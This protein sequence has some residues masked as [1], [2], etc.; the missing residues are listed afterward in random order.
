MEWADASN[1]QL[2]IDKVDTFVATASARAKQLGS[3]LP[4]IY[5]NDASS[6]QNPL[7]SYGEASFQ[8]IKTIAG[9]YDP[10]GIMQKVQNNGFLVSRS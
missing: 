9:K 10:S 2:A 5:V 7:R 6:K 8:Y 4:Y 1:T 3:F